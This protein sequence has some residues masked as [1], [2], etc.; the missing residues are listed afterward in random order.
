[1]R[2]S[3][4]NKLKLI[5]SQLYARNLDGTLPTEIGTLTELVELY[6]YFI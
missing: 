3:W 1:M 2:A 4:K 5:I 6:D